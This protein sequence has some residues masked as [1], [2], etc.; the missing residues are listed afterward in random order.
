[1]RPVDAIRR[2]R[3]GHRLAPAEIAD[4]VRGVTDGTW[5]DPQVAA[6]LMA[7][8]LRGMSD[9]ETA[10]LTTAMA[11]SGAVLDLSDLPG[12]TV[13][14]HST[15]G[16]G[17]KTSLLIAPIVAAAGALVPMM[18]GRGL[19]HTGGTLDKLEAIPGVRTTLPIDQFKAIVGRIGCAI[20]GQTA[21][22]A[23]ADR[24]LY[25]LRDVTGTVESIPLIT[26]SILSKKIAEGTA[27]LVLDVKVG[28][29]AFMKDEDAALA[30]A[31]ALVAAGQAAGVRTEAVVTDMDAPL[32]RTVG[33]ALEVREAVDAL[34][35]RGPDDLRALT[36]ALAGAHAGRRWRRQRRG[37][38]RAPGRCGARLG[39]GPRA[40]SPHGRRA[41]RRPA[42]CR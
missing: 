18:S 24:R 39:R 13:D 42:G 22:I 32:G 17:D 36:L 2:K 4:V 12:P 9:D 40:L 10:A 34:A 11:Q 3:D 27:A 21:E 28:S 20:V 16:V 26:A 15:G 1:M 14:K 5:S 38:R 31:R 41:G 37:R 8:V 30:L 6:W 19:G 7:V 23:P 25:A 29:G 35:G 33:N